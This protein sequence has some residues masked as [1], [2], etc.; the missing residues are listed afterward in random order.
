[1]RW[2][3]ISLRYD[4]TDTFHPIG[5]VKFLSVQPWAQQESLPTHSSFLL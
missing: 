4:K 3:I 2:L 1:M 5:R